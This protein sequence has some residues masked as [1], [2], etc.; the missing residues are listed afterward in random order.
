M[1]ARWNREA[2]T[3]TKATELPSGLVPEGVASIG[4]NRLLIV[5]DLKEAILI[6]TEH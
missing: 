3:L 4:E 6:A 2:H 5:D 1:L